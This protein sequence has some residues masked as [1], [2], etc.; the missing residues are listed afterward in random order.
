M[1]RKFTITENRLRH[2]ISETVRE[3]IN[4]DFNEEIRKQAQ[5]RD[6]AKQALR[7]IG[8]T[9]VSDKGDN[10]YVLM[11]G[12]EGMQDER[13]I[14]MALQRAL[15]PDSPYEL[16]VKVDSDLMGVNYYCKVML[17]AYTHC[18]INL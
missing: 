11:F 6:I 17:P 1:K 18:N 5:I 4:E 14:E 10:P 12:V 9:D 2:M 15:R 3:L 16:S 13:R 7:Q 8:Y